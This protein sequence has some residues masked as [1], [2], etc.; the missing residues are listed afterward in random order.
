MTD[1]R[2]NFP[3]A[4]VSLLA[5]GGWH[6]QEDAPAAFG[7]TLRNDK[8]GLDRLAQTNLIGEHHTLGKRRRQ[9]LF[10]QALQS[11]PVGEE[12]ALVGSPPLSFPPAVRG[13]RRSVRADAGFGEQGGIAVGRDHARAFGGKRKR[14][15]PS[16]ALSRRGDEDRLVPETHMPAP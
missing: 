6:D 7:P 8:R 9:R 14:R 12:G 11:D 3:P 2:E 1:G 4:L 16:D 13:G 10:S 5:Q 15:G